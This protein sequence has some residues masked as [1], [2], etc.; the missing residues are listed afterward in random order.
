MSSQLVASRYK[1]AYII[2]YR[3]WRIQ[4]GGGSVVNQEG[5]QKWGDEGAS[6][7][8][9]LLGTKKLQSAHGSR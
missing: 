2:G 4:Q 9:Q 8:T 7:I 3:Q 6:G 5:R 1:S